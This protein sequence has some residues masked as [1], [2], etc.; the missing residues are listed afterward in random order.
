MRNITFKI[1][2]DNQK[3]LKDGTYH[4]KLRI[5]TPKKFIQ[6][7]GVF[8][9]AEH[10]DDSYGNIKQEFVSDYEEISKYINEIYSRVAEIRQP[11][12]KN[13]IST[14]TAFDI[15][16]GLNVI[17]GSVL[18]FASTYKPDAKTG[19]STIDKH[20]ANL[21]AIN[22]GLSDNNLKQH[23]PIEFSH[24]QDESCIDDIATVIKTKMQLATNTQSSYMKSL[25]WVCK[26]AKLKLNN[27][28][29]HFG[30]MVT[31]IA[32]GKNE[33]ISKQDLQL[34]YN[35]IRTLHQFEALCFW[36]YSFCLMGLDGRDIA[37]LS[38]D[39]I[40]TKGYKR[41]DLNDF[42]PDADILG[43]KDYSKPL[44]VHIKRGKTRRGATDSGVDAIFQVNLFP[45]LIVL[46]LLKH[47]IKHNVNGYAY[48]GSDRLKLYNFDVDTQE[49]FKEW[50]KCRNT[51]TSQMNKHVGTTTQQ[52]RHTVTNVAGQIGLSQDDVDSLLNHTIKGVNRHYWTKQQTQTDVSHTHIFQHYDIIAIVKNLLTMF[53]DRVEIIGNKEVPFIPKTIMTQTIQKGRFPLLHREQMFELGVLS[54]FS[55]EDEIRYHTLLKETLQG[56]TILKDGIMQN[57]PIKEK[58]YPKELKKLIEKRKQLYVKP[59]K[60]KYDWMSQE[61][62]D[63]IDVSTSAVQD[64][65]Q[66]VAK[67]KEI[68]KV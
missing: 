48:E 45:T 59:P 16:K 21:S 4:L 22:T 68:L 17:K 43:N 63:K 6:R 47:A 64:G 1:T 8:V 2:T 31:E 50:T 33:P 67:A 55:R 15:L 26:K 24:L 3:P 32:S 60:L 34:G 38:E 46:E 57:V 7:S 10:W 14:K 44:H 19:Q 52:A 35:K 42:V 65:S 66:Q 58:D 39:N 11:L 5:K 29:T 51:Y 20:I 13:E 37:G 9:K 27:P 23:V 62:L 12:Q 18:E 56:E 53:K 28:F 61:L 25:N 30:Y 54:K 49:G 36:L 40:K 41:G